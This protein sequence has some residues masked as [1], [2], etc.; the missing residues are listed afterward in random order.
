MRVDIARALA[1]RVSGATDD[2]PAVLTSVADQSGRRT[3]VLLGDAQGY[4][5]RGW[6]VLPLWWP[7]PGGAC[8]CGRPDCSKPGKHPLTRHDR[9]CAAVRCRTA[10]E[11]ESSPR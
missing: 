3:D 8:A 10:C 4:A 11:A 2:E 1:G 6:P 5:E 7:L 9:I